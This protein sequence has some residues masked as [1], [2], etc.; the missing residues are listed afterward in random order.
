MGAVL[1]SRRRPLA[2]ELDP[3]ELA[4]L[5]A[6]YTPRYDFQGVSDESEMQKIRDRIPGYATSA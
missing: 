2:I 5:E 6:P 3:E 4:A 1:R